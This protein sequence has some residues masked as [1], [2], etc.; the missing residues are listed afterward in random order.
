MAD[1]TSDGRPAA[2]FIAPIMPSDR[3]NGL[4]MRTGFLLD[5]YAKRYAVDLAVVLVAGGTNELTPFV[6]ARTLR[7]I[8]LPPGAPDTH[9]ALLGSLSNPEARLAAFRHYGRPSITA[10]LSVGLERTL[11]GFTDDT[12]Y[13]LVHVSRLYLASLAATWMPSGM[14]PLCLVLDCD[15]DDARAYR[16]LA[17]LNRN[18]GRDRLAAWADAEADAF[19]ALATQWLP[20][21]DLRLAASSSEAR[22]L[23][24]RVG[25]TGITVIPNVV[26]GSAAGTAPRRKSGGH[27]E[28]LFVGNMSYLPNIDAA[29]WF[30][31]RIWPKLRSAVPYPLRFIIA[32]PGAP[33]EVMDLARRPDIVVAGGFDDV[34]PLYRRAT[35]AVVPIRAGGGTRIKLL[36]SA[37]YGV[38]VVATRFGAEGTGL[39]SGQEL[40]LADSE[41]DF[42]T[43]CAR[44]LTDGGLASRLAARALARVSRDFAAGRLA[45]R[46]LAAIDAHCDTGVK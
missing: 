21:F 33:R 18:W 44:L 4:A 38:P 2:L 35:L 41:L 5:T 28:I 15:E 10:R 25:R 26:P 16:R 23:G 43:S 11:L 20:R 22:W 7:V 9:F 34:A 36:E 30:A 24:A 46:L 31:L 19:K 42:A 17:R 12:S 1:S 6:K 37:K 27:R 29:M 40:L 45:S 3:G 13:R 14:R 32:G 8:V 39:R